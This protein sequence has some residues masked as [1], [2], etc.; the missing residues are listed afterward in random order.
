VG[1]VL[2]LVEGKKYLIPNPR[3]VEDELHYQKELKA[4][5]NKLTPYILLAG[6]LPEIQAKLNSN[7]CR[8]DFDL[9][10]TSD[11]CKFSS[12]FFNHGTSI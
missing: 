3:I 1:R 11:N 2:H 4:I 6:L 9:I 10:V 5:E 12:W 7:T 8:N